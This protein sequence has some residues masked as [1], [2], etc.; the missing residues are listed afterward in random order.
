MCRYTKKSHLGF[1][2]G[3]ISCVVITSLLIKNKGLRDQINDDAVVSNVAPVTSDVTNDAPVTSGVNKCISDDEICRRQ[4]LDYLRKASIN[5]ENN[6]ENQTTADEY[7]YART[8]WQTALL[9]LL[10]F[11][12]DYNY[13]SHVVPLLASLWV[14]DGAILE[15]G[16][17]Y[18]STPV[19]HRI[20][21]KY[22]RHVVTAENNYSWLQIF[23]T[24]RSDFHDLYYV[25]GNV[26]NV[27]S[28]VHVT[29]A[30]ETPRVRHSHWSVVFIDHEPGAQRF[31]D[32][33]LLKNKADLVVIHDTDMT[34]LRMYE[35]ENDN[36]LKSFKYRSVF[37]HAGMTARYT[38]VL[39][40]AHSDLVTM[41][42]G[43]CRWA[44]DILKNM[45]APRNLR[46]KAQGTD[47]SKTQ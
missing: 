4:T 23:L 11:P 31:S 45:G 46:D 33:E 8:C 41:V 27:D 40:N 20:A 17:G 38:D 5:N 37:N 30:W 32:L 36:M 14:T 22:Q 44:F 9:S 7:T 2:A 26:S 35:Q 25:G 18:Y 21:Q 24:F 47:E 3:L 1:I 34:S 16:S 10:S 13:G 28:R 42:R 43:L 15:L 19:T 39:S 6:K 29:T 12:L